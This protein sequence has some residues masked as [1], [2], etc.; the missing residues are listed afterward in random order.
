[1]ALQR[2][3]RV[4]GEL[5]RDLCGLCDLAMEIIFLVPEPGVQRNRIF[6]SHDF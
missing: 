1:M 5:F 3:D 6:P 4:Q 2:K